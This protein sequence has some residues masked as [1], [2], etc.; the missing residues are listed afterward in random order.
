MNTQAKIVAKNSLDAKLSFSAYIW[1]WGYIAIAALTM[2]ATLPGRT[3]GLGLFTKPLLS[4]LQLGNV[5]YANYNL[6]A[7][8]VGACFC[9]PIGYLLDR[10]GFRLVHLITTL[11]LALTV[12]ILSLIQEKESLSVFGYFEVR[13]I[14]LTL[15]IMTRGLGQSMLSVI[16]LALFGKLS[17]GQAGLV[18]GLYSFLVAITFMGAFAVLTSGLVNYGLD[19]RILLQ[20]IALALAIDA[21]IVFICFTI[22]PVESLNQ[23]SQ[24]YDA[25]D[26][27]L[28]SSELPS[29]ESLDSEFLDSELSSK[30]S[31]NPS[32]ERSTIPQRDST[33]KEALS[34]AA[35]WVFALATSLYGLTVAGISLFNQ[36]ILEDRGFDAKVFKNIT[37]LSPIVG[38]FSNLITGYLTRSISMPKLMAAGM[39][40]FATA[41]LFFPF[42]QTLPMVYLYAVVL[43]LAGGMVTVIFFAVWGIMYGVQNLGSIQGVAQKLTVLASAFGPILLAWRFK[44]DHSYTPIFR[45]LAFVAIAFAVISL[46]IPFPN[47][48]GNQNKIS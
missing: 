32:E 19:Y 4:D 28:A 42:V 23:I 31:T 40:L 29:S 24:S 3:Q 46:L 34:T 7:T 1:F 5:E 10:F 16:S 41:L 33:L 2:T 37:I 12:F 25:L 14:L 17:R 22:S 15:L 45:E 38:L 21:A 20:G 30:T 36:A 35:F 43:G 9:L 39:I 6:I 47:R 8:L 27:N 11:S 26:S 48:L 44:I 18:S 13:P